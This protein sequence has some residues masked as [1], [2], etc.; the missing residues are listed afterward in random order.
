MNQYCI[1]P[2]YATEFHMNNVIANKSG[3]LSL[4]FNKSLITISMFHFNVSYTISMFHFIV[5]YFFYKNCKLSYWHNFTIG[6]LICQT[7]ATVMLKELIYIDNKVHRNF[8]YEV[9]LR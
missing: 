6:I 7:S 9:Q 4:C 3:R 5:S 2:A 8:M 1:L